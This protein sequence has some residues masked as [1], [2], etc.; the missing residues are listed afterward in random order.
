MPT[1]QICLGSNVYKGV[2]VQ[3][4]DSH[5]SLGTQIACVWLYPHKQILGRVYRS[6][7]VGPLV[8]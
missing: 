4:V 5:N 1:M 7:L 2:A 3:Y 6:E 8:C